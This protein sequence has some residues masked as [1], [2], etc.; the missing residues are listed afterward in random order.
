MKEL[1]KLNEFGH[2]PVRNS[3]SEMNPMSVHILLGFLQ[4]SCLI[5]V[6]RLLESF[7]CVNNHFSFVSFTYTSEK[8][9]TYN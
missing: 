9:K 8:K 5:L 6:S 4:F 1:R 7:V 2:A 3:T